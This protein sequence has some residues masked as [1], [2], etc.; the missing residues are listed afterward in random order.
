LV[1]LF[2]R[3]LEER[4]LRNSW[5]AMAYGDATDPLIF[6]LQNSQQQRYRKK[7]IRV[8]KGEIGS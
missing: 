5:T 8:R 7:I 2:L 6:D 1:S 3:L 4:L